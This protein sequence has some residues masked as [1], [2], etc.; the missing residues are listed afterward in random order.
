MKPEETIDAAQ[1]R[2]EHFLA[3]MT[4]MK[5]GMRVL[6]AG[7]GVGGPAREMARFAGVYV[8]GVSINKKHIE[9][10]AQYAEKDGLS[11]LTEFI[12]ADFTVRNPGLLPVKIRLQ[13]FLFALLGSVRPS[14][15]KDIGN[16]AFSADNLVAPV[17]TISR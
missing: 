6:D 9:L 15:K 14:P 12:E 16:L 10:A 11:D 3:L 17:S 13:C 7:C 5:P 8:T 2:H 4:G 1:C